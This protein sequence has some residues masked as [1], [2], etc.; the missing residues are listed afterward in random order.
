MDSTL[1]IFA[2]TVNQTAEC[3]IQEGCRT[4]F[5]SSQKV[6]RGELFA[7]STGQPDGGD[8]HILGG[9]EQVEPQFPAQSNDAQYIFGDTWECDG[10]R[11]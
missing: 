3:G 6:G 10:E 8:L 11:H 7:C 4:D 5:S 9:D 1:P 2:K